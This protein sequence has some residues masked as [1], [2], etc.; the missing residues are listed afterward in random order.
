M[1]QVSPVQQYRT[2][3]LAGRFFNCW[4][5]A[6]VFQEDDFSSLVSSVMES[7]P[8][9]QRVVF[10]ASG[11]EGTVKQK[12]V[13]FNGEVLSEGVC[14]KFMLLD[15]TYWLGY[16]DEKYAD[17]SA[18]FTL[19]Q[20]IE[21]DGTVSLYGAAEGKA[22]LVRRQPWEMV[23]IFFTEWGLSELLVR[24]RG[25]TGVKWGN[26]SNNR[27]YLSS[28]EIYRVVLSPNV[29]LQAGQ[30]LYDLGRLEALVDMNIPQKDL[31]PNSEAVRSAM[32]E[33]EIFWALH[34]SKSKNRDA[35]QE[36]RFNMPLGGLL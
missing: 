25:Q 11:N 1:T 27:F 34:H 14:P 30:D 31:D 5:A 15:V 7:V 3:M 10:L 28:E 17:K 20:K 9:L 12:F 22:G 18:Y 21:N 16:L 2:G 29:P 4:D 19:I 24:L 33:Y 8:C 6:G 35:A 13:S 26:F 32:Q 36:S 23:E